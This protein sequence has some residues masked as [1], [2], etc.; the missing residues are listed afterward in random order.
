MANKFEVQVVALDRFTKTF[1]DL[2]NQASKA[3]RPL[4]NI[5][6]QVGALTREMHLDKMAKGMGKVTNAALGMSRAVGLTLGP[7]EGVLGIGAAGGILGA[8][9]ATAVGLTVL[10]TKFAG[11][12]AEAKR[13]SDQLGIQT[14]QLQLWR[15]AAK[16]AHV[17]ADTFTQS[18]FAIRETLWGAQTLT[19]PRAAQALEYLGIKI[20]HLAD[21]SI[22]VIGTTR[23]IANALKGISDPHVRNAVAEVFHIDPES[24]R[25]LQLGTDEIDKLLDKARRLGAADGKNAIAW[26]VDFTKSLDELGVAADGAWRTV[27]R[28]VGP[29]VAKGVDTVTKG[30]TETGATHS[31]RGVLEW[32][33]A[34]AP[35][36]IGGPFGSAA[37]AGLHQY[38]QTTRE[39]DE[40]KAARQGRIVSGLVGGPTAHGEFNRAALL[41]AAAASA[42][43]SPG[44]MTMSPD[45]R[46]VDPAW[47]AR[48][49]AA[50]LAV[51]QQ[52]LNNDPRISPEDRA[53]LQ[54]EISRR[55][56]AEGT[57]RLSVEVNFKNAPAGTTA[58]A[59]TADGSF[60]PTRVSTSMPTSSMP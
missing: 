13:T 34:H 16:L 36:N 48:A 19:D 11:S 18:L 41:A 30:L 3:A 23:D 10:T 9:G 32:L 53:A 35:S 1:R 14:D 46:H 59:R 50:G 31:G 27:G 24:L 12:A 42:P 6:R 51:V 25:L 29:F 7:L 38:L 43:A 54:R 39:L 22:D 49:D 57:G 20:R 26:S 45:G 15:A 55:Q 60:V 5:H 21:G 37:I 58:T 33:T 2:N 47:Q 40:A 8:I 4:V 56:A 17:D 52:E 44:E 28:L